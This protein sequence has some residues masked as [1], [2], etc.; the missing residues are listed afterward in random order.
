MGETNGKTKAKAGSM[1]DLLSKKKDPS[2][3]AQKV[4]APLREDYPYV[5]ELL[6]G[7]AESGEQKAISPGTITLFVHEGKARFSANV[8]SEEVTFIGDLEDIVNPLGSINTA[9]AMGDVSSKRYT[10]PASSSQKDADCLL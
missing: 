4:V 7:M 1:R 6:G 9:L 5:A 3:E 10:G 2:V 8:K